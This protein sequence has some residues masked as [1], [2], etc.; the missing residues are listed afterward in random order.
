MKS[1]TINIDNYFTSEKDM[2]IERNQLIRKHNC[3]IYGY[4]DDTHKR[5][6]NINVDEYSNHIMTNSEFMKVT[7]QYKSLQDYDSDKFKADYLISNNQSLPIDL[8]Q[9]LI[10]T[11]KELIKAGIYKQEWFIN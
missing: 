8:E 11:K 4:F 9:R 7:S 2:L 10:I 1:Y 3:G 6:A 5:K